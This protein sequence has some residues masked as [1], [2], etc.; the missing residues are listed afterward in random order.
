[1]AENKTQLYAV[2]KRLTL[3]VRTHTVKAKGWRKI[4]HANGNEKKVGVAILISDKI[5]LKIK[6]VIKDKKDI[7]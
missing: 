6:T 7:T 5:D 1:M 2:Y 4:F 3:E